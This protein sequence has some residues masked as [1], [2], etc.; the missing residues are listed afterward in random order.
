MGNKI[1]FSQIQAKIDRLQR[2]RTQVLEHLELVERKIK[3]LNDAL[4]VMEDEAL[5]D[6]YDTEVYLQE[7][8][9]LFTPQVEKNKPARPQT[10]YR[11]S[12]C[13]AASQCYRN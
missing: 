12:N 8:V 6:E 9:A 2:E 10:A 1:Y 3:K 11:R 7:N 13:G 5:T 4:E